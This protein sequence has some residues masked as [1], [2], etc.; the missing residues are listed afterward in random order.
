V[1]FQEISHAADTLL[2]PSKR[3]LYDN[4]G[5]R[6]N[7][8]CSTEGNGPPKGKDIV[9]E[10]S[11]TLLQLYG[12]KTFRLAVKRDKVC[13][14]CEGRGG[15]PGSDV[16]CPDCEGKGVKV[17]RRQVGPN[18]VQQMQSVC[19]SCKGA[20]KIIKESD[21][22][23]VC[24]GK[25]TS[26]DRKIFQCHVEK[27]MKHGQ[28]IRFNE[29]ADEFPGSIAGDVIFVVKE[30]PHSVFERKG[31][32]L[33]M[34]MQVTLVEALCRFWKSFFHLDGRVLQI[35]SPPGKIITPGSI[36]LI[37]GEGMPH[38]GDPFKKGHL[39][40]VFEVQFPLQM[41]LSPE[42][43]ETLRECLCL[44]DANYTPNM[45]TPE[46]ATKTEPEIEYE[47]HTFTEVDQAAFQNML[48]SS[49]NEAADNNTDN[50]GGARPMQCQAS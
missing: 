17:E 25:K 27:G 29:E 23:P 31:T 21:K 18:M 12:G 38:H 30:E 32:A 46:L 24:K 45:P 4:G 28:Q 1:Q 11:V 48:A 42:R 34:R 36:H 33:I 16:I 3:A 6:N 13:T 47:E 39:F 15:P 35:A 5:F 8:S 41:T 9:H 50:D 19:L 37:N 49:I 22:C 44:L 20:C 10:V 2:D 7:T 43:G 14:D 26:I 40:I